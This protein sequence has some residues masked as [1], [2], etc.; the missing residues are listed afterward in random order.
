VDWNKPGLVVH[1][2]DKA[3][4]K[5]NTTNVTAEDYNHTVYPINEAAI[6][7]SGFT[8]LRE[9]RLSYDVPASFA[10]KVRATQMNIAFVGRNLATWTKFPNYDPEN[11][12]S[13]GNGGQGYDMGAM[14]TTRSFGINFT[15]TP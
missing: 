5:P 11:S 4:G 10:A 7:N 13:A 3:S 6:Y 14:P 1:G 2:I 12:T 9:V 8:K 15:I